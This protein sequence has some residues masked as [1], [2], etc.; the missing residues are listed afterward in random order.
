MPTTG[1]VDKHGLDEAFEGNS[2]E[3]EAVRVSC[4]EFV[5]ASVYASDRILRSQNHGRIA[6]E[7]R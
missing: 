7:I 2:S 6:Y 1:Y 4:V 5:L 3:N